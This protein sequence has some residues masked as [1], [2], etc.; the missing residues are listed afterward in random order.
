MSK[1]L[2]DKIM[3]IPC[4]GFDAAYVDGCNYMRGEAAKLA[5][6]AAP[7]VVA[8]EL[9]MQTIRERDFNAEMADNLANGIAEHF[10]ADIGE[11]S[12]ANC[13]WVQA[14]DL[15]N[16]KP[17]FIECA[18]S[19]HAAAPVQAQ[20]PVAYMIREN[21]MNNPPTES[22]SV[23]NNGWSEWAPTS[24]KHGDSVLKNGYW[25]QE[26]KPLFLA[27][28][29]PV[30]VPDGWKLVPIE[31]TQEMFSKARTSAFGSSSEKL[32][33]HSYWRNMLAAAPAAPAAQGDTE[34]AR[35]AAFKEAIDACYKTVADRA[36]VRHIGDAAH[37]SA[38]A[39][40]IRAIAAKAAL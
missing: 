38:C 28:V 34:T 29:Q 30:A 20:E 21:R 16:T 6:A 7:Q 13:P 40:A 22:C 27:P 8:D 25:F 37:Y 3:A 9:G 18:G 36:K 4:Y 23:P 14:L 11:H 31:P 24:K 35:Q 26:V 5:L 17:E 33:M 39:D 19:K 10:G 15:L 2:H 12:S 32:L 1:A